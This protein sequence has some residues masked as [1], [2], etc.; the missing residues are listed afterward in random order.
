MSGIISEDGIEWKEVVK[1]MVRGA[2]AKK[3]ILVTDVRLRL[4]VLLLGNLYRRVQ[5]SKQDPQGEGLYKFTT[6][7]ELLESLDDPSEH[8]L[9]AVRA[10]IRVRFR[11]ME[12]AVSRGET[13]NE[14][15]EIESILALL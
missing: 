4:M 1:I 2:L 6:A 10:L 13:I 11:Q 9:E 7:M 5:D 12:M 15:R 3:G 14:K 8:E